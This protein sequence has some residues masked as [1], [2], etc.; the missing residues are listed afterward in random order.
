MIYDVTRLSTFKHVP[1]WLNEIS[2]MCNEETTVV[3]VGNKI[4]LAEREVSTE[5]GEDL[6]KQYGLK[7]N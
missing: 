2:R 5:Q 7:E 6:A 4:D 3:I 1:L